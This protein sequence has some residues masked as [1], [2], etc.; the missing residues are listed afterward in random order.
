MTCFSAVSFVRKFSVRV[1][2]RDTRF[3]KWT[4]VAWNKLILT[5]TETTAN[6]PKRCVWYDL[7]P[8]EAVCELSTNYAVRD[9]FCSSHN[10]QSLCSKCWST[11]Y[12]FTNVSKVWCNFCTDL[13]QKDSIIRNLK[14]VDLSFDPFNVLFFFSKEWREIFVLG[15]NS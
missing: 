12:P 6:P 11:R 3:S 8:Q 14:S 15:C 7:E 2:V 5:T 10:L 9:D 1:T 4:F 13:C